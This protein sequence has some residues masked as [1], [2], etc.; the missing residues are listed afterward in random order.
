VAY[1]SDFEFCSSSLAK[2]GVSR[3]LSA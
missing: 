2:V 3:L 1:T